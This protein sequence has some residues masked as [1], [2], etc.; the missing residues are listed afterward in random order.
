[1]KRLNVTNAKLSFTKKTSQFEGIC[2]ECSHHIYNYK[3]C[4]HNF[5]DGRCYLFY[6]DGS[7]QNTFKTLKGLNNEN[8][9]YTYKF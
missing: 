9:N 2:P 7:A 8:Y 5:S 4:I 6:W 3:N 1:M